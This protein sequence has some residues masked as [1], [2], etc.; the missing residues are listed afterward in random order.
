VI[1]RREFITLLGGAAAWPIAA[2]A[3][4]R[5]ATPVVGYF[6]VGSPQTRAN[7]VA[8]FR[9]G[10]REM[11]YVEGKD[12]TI[13]YHWANDQYDKLPTMA[14]ELVRRQ[15]AVIVTPA[16]SG[17]AIASKAATSTIP[18]VFAI[19]DDPVKYGLVAN[20]AR[21]GG[22]AT[23]VSYFTNELSAKRLGLLQDLVPN[24]NLIGILVNPN[25][26]TAESQLGEVKEAARA[27]GQA[28]EILYAS[29][30]REIDGAFE[31]LA[32][33]KGN[34]LV[35]LPDTVFNS[36]M[37]QIVT[38]ATRDRIPAIYQSREWADAGG[39]MS[40]GTSIADIHRQVGIYTGR[41]LKGEKPANLPVIQ[42]TRFE[43]V[44]NLQTAKTIG[45][46]VSNSMQLL[47][48]D[49]IE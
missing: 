34:G 24:T 23:G 19:G 17:A 42:P 16:S 7:I 30:N 37:V 43:L 4:E 12:V 15:V 46:T 36:R 1:Q 33:K 8:A 29:N 3:Q 6:H 5:P 35:V 18:I 41:I 14:A 20:L 32:F 31:I 2:P 49:L 28:I 45:L 48:D 26:P 25:G 9:Q 40:Y 11:G 13:E 47:A 10:L 44:I 39:L 22:N 21:P 27:V 38:L